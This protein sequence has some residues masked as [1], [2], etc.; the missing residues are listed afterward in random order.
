MTGPSSARRRTAARGLGGGRRPRGR[1]RSGSW[2]PRTESTCR[3]ICRHRGDR[4]DRQ[5]RPTCAPA[6]SRGARRGRAPT[7]EATWM[8]DQT[9]FLQAIHDTDGNP[10]ELL[11][12]CVP[13]T[14]WWSR[15]RRGGLRPDTGPGGGRRDRCLSM[16]R[17]RTP[18][19]DLSPSTGA[20][21]APSR[22]C[23]PPPR[24]TASPTSP[25]SRRPTAS[26]KSASPCRTS[27]CRRRRATSRQPRGPACCSSTR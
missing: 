9:A 21:A 27:S 13:V 4:G 19:F 11:E 17:A 8:A 20:S 18:A 25:T 10:I 12:R 26:T 5:R 1:P 7:P 22:R 15:S 3:H 2:S 24:P 6:S 16:T 14:V 23:W